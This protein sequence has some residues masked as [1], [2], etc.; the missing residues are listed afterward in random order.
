MVSEICIC[1]P[2]LC[3]IDYVA[4]VLL[5]A[6]LQRVTG[7]GEGLRR[8][9]RGTAQGRWRGEPPDEIKELMGKAHIALV[10]NR[11]SP[12]PLTPYRPVCKPPDVSE[13]CQCRSKVLFAGFRVLPN[14]FLA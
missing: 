13:L 10:E 2:F 7:G 1:F 11:H 6:S 4:L 8:R 14:A 12:S 9:R 3:V 5:T